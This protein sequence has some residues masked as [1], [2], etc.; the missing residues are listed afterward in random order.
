MSGFTSKTR[1]CL[2]NVW[3]KRN[4]DGAGNRHAKFFKHVHDHLQVSS[5]WFQVSA[6]AL[7]HK[8]NKMLSEFL[9]FTI[10]LEDPYGNS[11]IIPENPENLEVIISEQKNK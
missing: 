8:I 7:K 3:K 2:L 4:I 11:K 6:L 1:D 10:I 5:L 9:P